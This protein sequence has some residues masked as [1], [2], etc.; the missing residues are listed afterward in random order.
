[1]TKR[2]IPRIGSTTVLYCFTELS[3]Q[4]SHALGHEQLNLISMNR[5][6]V[7]CW[8]KRKI[9]SLGEIHGLHLS[10]VGEGVSVVVDQLG[11]IKYNCDISSVSAWNRSEQEELRSLLRLNLN[12]VSSTSSRELELSDGTLGGWD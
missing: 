8:S 3:R 1:M 12:L 7:G 6:L 5:H 4:E 9:E 2:R 10:T 11:S